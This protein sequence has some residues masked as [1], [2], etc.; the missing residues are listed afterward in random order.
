M[1]GPNMT[2]EEELTLHNPLVD[3]GV[4]LTDLRGIY[5]YRVEQ[6]MAN[7]GDSPHV[8]A[9]PGVH[10]PF[11]VMVETMTEGAVMLSQDGKI[12]YCNP[13]FANV[14]R[15]SLRDVIGSPFAAWVAD[16]CQEN[17]TAGLANAAM[18]WRSDVRLM[19]GDGVPMSVQLSAS[20]LDLPDLARGMCLVVLDMTE[21]E[22]RLALELE[23]QA[24]RARE[25][26]LCERQQELEG[27]NCELGSANRRMVAL[28]AELR[29]KARQLK[30][31]DAMKT[32]FLSNVSHEFR[33][34]LHTIFGITSLLL[35][36]TEGGLSNEQE[37]LVGYLRN[38]ADALLELVNDLL[39][40]AKI[41][42]GKIEIR[43]REF[44]VTEIFAMINGMLPPSLV[45]P[46]VELVFEEPMNDSALYSDQ[47]KIAQ[48]LRNLIGNALKFTERGEVRIS[49]HHDQEN[50]RITFFVRDTGI[51]IAAD[52]YEKIFD[53]FTQ[54]ENP[55]QSKVKGTGLG[56]PLCRKLA[57][58]LGGHIA[59]ESELGAGATFSLVVPRRYMPPSNE[60]SSDHQLLGSRRAAGERLA[61]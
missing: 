5:N 28:Y 13:A 20:L 51:G 47:G 7:G 36:R 43:P 45:D 26:V 50:D 39:D 42:A 54:L 61:G 23:Q 22:R 49:A 52:D 44:R 30:R 33:S 18:P 35:S 19:R 2:M 32:R 17:F 58:L 38:A 15:S 1:R 4:N 3:C 55:A 37:K 40:L 27:L 31:A 16:E 57:T 46:A 24:A 6:I 56:L 21:H 14:L 48:I 12:L 41:E 11:R 53:E 8:L 60:T 10:D 29:E 9:M 34:P 25:E 59:V